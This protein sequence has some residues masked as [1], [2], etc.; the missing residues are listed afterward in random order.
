MIAGPTHSA[1]EAN[2]RA[3][4]PRKSLPSAVRWVVDKFLQRVKAY[5][6]ALI[7]K[8]CVHVS[9]K[10]CAQRLLGASEGQPTKADSFVSPKFALACF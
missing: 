8:A 2:T 1:M 5:R 7:I 10:L 9:K 3:N 6:Q 4:L